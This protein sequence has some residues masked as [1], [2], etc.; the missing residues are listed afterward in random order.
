[1]CKINA[2]GSWNDSRNSEAI[3]Q[4]LLHETPDRYYLIADSAFLHGC[5]NIDGRIRAP[6]TVCSCLPSDENSHARLLAFDRQ[7][8]SYRQTAEWGNH[9][10]Q[11]TF[12][13]LRLP[14]SA[15]DHQGRADL[16]Q[17]CVRLHN[18]RTRCVGLNQIQTVYMPADRE[19]RNFEE[20]IFPSG[21]RN[22]RVLRFQAV[23][24]A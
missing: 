6:L 23:A 15:F 22:S 14:L 1:M 17:I 10:L 16:I 20:R 11:S 2:P 8:L 4:K 7:V 13:Q 12:G 5:T 18:V 21:I 9:I 3:Y 24:S 19:W